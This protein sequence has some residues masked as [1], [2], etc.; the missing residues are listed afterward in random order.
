MVAYLAFCSRG[1]LG[2][3]HSELK[4]LRVEKDKKEVEQK[5]EVAGKLSRLKHRLGCFKGGLPTLLGHFP[6]FLSLT[7]FIDFKRTKTFPHL[8]KL[9]YSPP[10]YLMVND[11][12]H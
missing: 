12:G 2:P 4:Y 1:Q 8:L 7:Y 10:K 9:I 5:Q 11:H 3:A 6:M